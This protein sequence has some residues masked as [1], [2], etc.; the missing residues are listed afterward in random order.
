RF[1]P[2]PEEQEMYKNIKLED[3]PNL[4]HED[5]FMLKLCEIPDL[6]KRLDLLLVIME[7]PCQYDDLAP[8]VKGLLEACHELYCSKKFPVVL[9]Y[10]LAIGNYINGG[11]NRGGAYGL[12][13][14]SLPK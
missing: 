5:R 11:T 6:D 1:L 12:R 13:L 4:L 10:I 9:E 14:T 8:A 3:V 7:F 2:T